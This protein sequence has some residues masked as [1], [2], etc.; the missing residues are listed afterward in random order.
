MDLDYYKLTALQKV[1]YKCKKL[2]GNF[3][4]KFV[5]FWKRLGRKIATFFINIYLN[6][7]DILFAWWHGNGITKASYL[8]MGLGHVCRGQIVKGIAYMLLEGAFIAYL[9][10]FGGHYLGMFFQHFFTAG[11]IG[12][13]ETHESNVWDDDLGEYVK[14][15]GDNSFHAILYGVLTLC[16]ILFFVIVYLRSIRESAQLEEDKI[17][18]KVPNNFKRDVGEMLDSKF[19]ITLLSLPLLGLFIFTVVPLITMI[20]IAFTDYDAAHEVPQY[21]FNW[22]GFKNFGAI[23]GGSDLGKTFWRV[24]GWT[25]IWAFFA[26]F[27]NYFGGMILAMLINK[28]GVKLKKLYRTMFVATIA[29]P[30]FVSLLIMSKMLDTGGGLMDSGGGIITQ[31]IEKLFNYHLMFGL[32]I[33]TTRI[34]IIVVNMWIGVPYSMLMCSGILMNIPQD[35]YESAKID[36]SGKVRTFMKITLPYML[37]VTGPYLITTFIGNIN[38]FNIIYL[39]SG[40][41]PG[42]LLKYSNGAQGTDLLITWLYKLSLGTNRDYKL[43]S[44]IGILVFII[45]AVFSLLV[46]NRSSAVKKEDDFQ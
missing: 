1:G 40:G 21:L 32:D 9:V 10:L 19:H 11:P 28:K 41:G 2:F 36:G 31:L 15:A 8:V 7:K 46:Y 22:V 39:L 35:L 42:D 18:G 34:C 20:L 33:T 4:Q 16:L 6:I 12:F 26:T 37:F 38:N 13:V 27:T 43:A 14:I 17:I 24:L 45:S 5:G 25:L 44:V 3:P 30:Q 23:L 29:V